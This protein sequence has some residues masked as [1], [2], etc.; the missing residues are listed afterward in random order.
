LR[1]VFEGS[2]ILA[3]VL[4][5]NPGRQ[6]NFRENEAGDGLNDADGRVAGGPGRTEA[7]RVRGFLAAD[8]L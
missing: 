4:A 7:V 2:I 3:W 1:G 8:Y 6:S 5:A